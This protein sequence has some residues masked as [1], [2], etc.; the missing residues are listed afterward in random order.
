[1][2]QSRNFSESVT[3]VCLIREPMFECHTNTCEP[4]LL[5]IAAFP[6]GIDKYFLFVAS[7]AEVRA[8][9]DRPEL[10]AILCWADTPAVVGGI[11]FGYDVELFI[12]QHLLGH[13]RLV[14]H[15]HCH[16]GNDCSKGRHNGNYHKEFDQ[17]EGLAAACLV[18]WKAFDHN[19]GLV[20]FKRNTD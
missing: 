15:S 19:N 16:G 12:P 3:R 8:E 6:Q 14:I 10:A 13:F 11:S 5:R 4:W 20:I 18:M 1:M 17:G 2:S 7:I 9:Y